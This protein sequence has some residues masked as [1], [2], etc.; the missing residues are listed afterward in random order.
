MCHALSIPGSLLM[1]SSSLIRADHSW[2]TITIFSYCIQLFRGH[3][4]LILSHCSHFFHFGHGIPCG[5]C[6]HCSPLN[7]DNCSI[8]KSLYKN[9][10]H[11]SP[12]FHGSHCLHV[13]HC[14]P[15]SPCGHGIVLGSHLSH[16][17][18]FFHGNHC[19]HG[20]HGFPWSGYGFLRSVNSHL[21]GLTMFS[22]LSCLPIPLVLRSTYCDPSCVILKKHPTS[23]SDSSHSTT[24]V[25]YRVVGWYG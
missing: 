15:C 7:T 11:F 23:S 25:S 22:S 10:S 16:F 2:Y 9:G 24:S 19:G 1:F 12:L 18:H 13:S 20:A 5:H 21:F 4:R 8:V 6:A 14:F 17:S 3:H